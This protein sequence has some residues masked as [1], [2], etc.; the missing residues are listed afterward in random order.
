MR[1]TCN[2][3]QQQTL[4]H[5]VRCCVCV[6]IVTLLFILSKIM[7]T[8]TRTHIAFICTHHAYTKSK[9]FQFVYWHFECMNAAFNNLLLRFSH[10]CTSHTCMMTLMLLL[11]FSRR[12]FSSFFLCTEVISMDRHM[13]QTSKYRSDWILNPNPMVIYAR[14]ISQC[15][16]DT[17]APST[18]SHQRYIIHCARI[19]QSNHE[20]FSSYDL[21]PIL[22]EQNTILLFN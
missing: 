1:H 2:L 5:T 15:S 21:S 14:L 11:R 8:H 6:S 20:S 12:L 13:T 10:V 16:I 9:Y 22:V 18:I 4:F 17:Y 19:Y 7:R 3:T